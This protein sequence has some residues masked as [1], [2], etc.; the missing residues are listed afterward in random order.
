MSATAVLDRDY[1]PQYSKRFTSFASQIVLSGADAPTRQRHL[2]CQV[3]VEVGADAQHLDYI[4]TNGVMV[5]MT[6][7]LKGFYVIRMAPSTIETST[8]V[9]GVTVFWEGPT[10]F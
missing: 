5:P 8:T 10:P 9:A 6:F 4:D 7:P 1:P 3:A 2:P